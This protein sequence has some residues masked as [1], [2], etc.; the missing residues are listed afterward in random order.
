MQFVST[1]SAMERRNVREEEG[2]TETDVI[3][4]F[5]Q[6][7]QSRLHLSG[8][9]QGFERGNLTSVTAWEKS[10]SGKRR[11]KA[12]STAKQTLISTAKQPV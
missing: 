2:G 5:K 11:T 12:K 10:V 9:E 6:S 1:V 3:C 8:T 4:N 7:Y